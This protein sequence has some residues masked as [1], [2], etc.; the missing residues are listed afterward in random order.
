MPFHPSPKKYSEPKPEL[1]GAQPE[2]AATP[3]TRKGRGRGE[4]KGAL[5]CSNLSQHQAPSPGHPCP[6]P[7]PGPLGS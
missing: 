1:Q 4:I 7:H 5:A 2:A 3:G 6:Y